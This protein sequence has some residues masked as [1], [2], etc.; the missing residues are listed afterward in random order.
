MRSG[1]NIL[2]VFRDSL[3]QDHIAAQ[4]RGRSQEHECFLVR[5]AAPHRRTAQVVPGQSPGHGR[6]VPVRAR[7][8]LG[9]ATPLGSEVGTVEG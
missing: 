3:S 1:A 8:R 7:L 2:A 6:P 5:Y 9:Q 4:R